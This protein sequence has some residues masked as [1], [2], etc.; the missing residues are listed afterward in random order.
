MR[1]GSR[2]TPRTGREEHGRL[3]FRPSRRLREPPS[4][5]AH[6]HGEDASFNPD[7]IF[8]LPLAAEAGR[9]QLRRVVDLAYADYPAVRGRVPRGRPITPTRDQLEMRRVRATPAG[10]E[11]RR[12]APFRGEGGGTLWSSSTATSR[13]RTSQGT[14]PAR[15]ITWLVSAWRQPATPPVRIP[16]TSSGRRRVPREMSVDCR[17]IRRNDRPGQCEVRDFGCQCRGL[18]RLERDL[19]GQAERVTSRIEQYSP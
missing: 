6:G 11:H 8:L 9:Q 5:R 2:Q 4:S 3:P 10:G 15:R 19:R 7:R 18:L 17:L 13:A 16:A 14:Q 12:G 1:P